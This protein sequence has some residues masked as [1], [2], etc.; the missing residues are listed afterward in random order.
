MIRW[1]M[2]IT[3]MLGDVVIIGASVVTLWFAPWWLSIPLVFITYKVWKSQGGFIAWTEW[4]QF[5]KNAK[6]MGL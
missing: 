1:M 3:C 6:E 5:M 4:R 2:Q